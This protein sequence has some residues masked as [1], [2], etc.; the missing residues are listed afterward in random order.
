MAERAGRSP[1]PACVGPTPFTMSVR[2]PIAVIHLA[3]ESAEAAEQL[4][5]TALPKECRSV[6]DDRLRAIWTGPGRW[7]LV[8]DE[9]SGE[10]FAAVR[11]LPADVAA[12]TD[13]SDARVC[14]H[15]AGD[16][17][18]LVLAKGCPVDLHPDSFAADDTV[19]SVLGLFR[20]LIDCRGNDAFDVYVARSYAKSLTD[21]LVAA[22]REYVGGVCPA[23]TS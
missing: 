21:W 14:L 20:V 2:Q 4:L 17:V 19:Q 5:Q 15:L 11:S 10:A 16:A 6:G 7:L 3:T 1:R 23:P 18:R 13:L 12:V 9:S 8:A 22:A